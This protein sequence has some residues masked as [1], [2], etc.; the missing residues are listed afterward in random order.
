MSASSRHLIAVPAENPVSPAAQSVLELY[1]SE[2]AELRFP[3]VDRETLAAAAARVVA[4]AESLAAAE[5]ALSAAREV[6]QDSQEALLGKCHRALAY[7]RIFAEDNPELTQ[8][9]EAIALPRRGQKTA[10]PVLVEQDL[11]RPGRRGR[12]SVQSGV[13]LLITTEQ[14]SSPEVEP[15]ALAASMH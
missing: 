8:R 12:R 4:D 9:I 11:S 13:P 1:A 2:L 6:L 5:A 10:S 7:A 14:P 3:D 15:E